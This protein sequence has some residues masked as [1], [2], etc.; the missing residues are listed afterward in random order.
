[1]RLYISGP[2]SG[3]PEFNAPMF[4]RVA[5]H[6]IDQGYEV[7]NPVT[8]DEMWGMPDEASDLE[9]G[10]VPSPEAHRA[11]MRRDLPMVAGCDGIVMLPGWWGSK[12]ANAELFVAL[13]SGLE[14]R[15][16]AL[17]AGHVVEVQSHSEIVAGARGTRIGRLNWGLLREMVA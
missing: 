7:I 11:F 10:G 8:L 15:R 14:V 1:M 9:P 4:D 6:Y 2:M 13:A 12:G 16:V 3:I 17:F 5:Q